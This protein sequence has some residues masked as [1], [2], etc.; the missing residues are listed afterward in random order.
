MVKLQA[1]IHISNACHPRPATDFLARAL[2]KCSRIG[3]SLVVE[4]VIETDSCLTHTDT[5]KRH[6]FQQALID[7][8]SQI[9]LTQH[10]VVARMAIIHI[11]TYLCTV[12]TGIY[13]LP[14]CGAYIQ[15][16]I[17]YIDR[18]AQEYPSPSEIR[19][20]LDHIMGR[21]RH[22][23]F[24]ISRRTQTIEVPGIASQCHYRPVVMLRFHVILVDIAETA[25]H[26]SKPVQ[27]LF[28]GILRFQFLKLVHR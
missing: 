7:S 8:L 14:S 11:S 15:T 3:E 21:E 9:H 19:A 13:A 27:F 12:Y 1:V 10:I 20:H 26:T 16:D 23:L 28:W 18:I 24:F 4:D 17:L 2:R 22:R 5:I 6:I 25:Y